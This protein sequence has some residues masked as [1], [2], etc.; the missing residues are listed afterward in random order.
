MSFHYLIFP[1]PCTGVKK[2]PNP[3]VMLSVSEALG[4]HLSNPKTGCIPPIVILSASDALVTQPVL[5]KV[6]RK[7]P[8]TPVILSVSEESVTHHV[9]PK[10][11]RNEP[12]TLVILS[13]AKNRSPTMR[14]QKVSYKE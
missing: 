12:S 11:G 14:H 9:L 6:S 10:V 7:A 13:A 2:E 3:T 5:P 8:A 4:T 1:L